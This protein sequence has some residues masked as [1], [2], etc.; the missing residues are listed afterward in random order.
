MSAIQRD[1]PVARQGYDTL[2]LPSAIIPYCFPPNCPTAPFP[3][4]NYA[5]LYTR[6]QQEKKDLG[7]QRYLQSRQPQFDYNTRQYSP[8]FNSSMGPLAT[9]YM[10]YD[11]VELR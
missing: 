4:G 9:N 10:N 11:T 6:S 2:T 1:Y 5:D 7:L 8:V 3:Y